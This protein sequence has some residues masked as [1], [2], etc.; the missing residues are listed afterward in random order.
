MTSILAAFLTVVALLPAVAAAGSPASFAMHEAPQDLPPITFQDDAGQ[1]LSLDAW[2]GKYVLLNVWATWCVPCR[3]E[4]PTLD[5]LQ[6]SLG[7]ETFEVLALSID[8]AGVE[9]VRRFYDEIGVANLRLLIDESGRAAG[10]WGVVGLPTTILVDPER[11]ELGRLIGP[12]EWDRPEMS[13]FILNVIS[14]WKERR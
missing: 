4:M 6:A 1:T 11:R 7:G 3:R 14:P 10:D 8:R 13:A 12:A 2:R 5:S 9:A